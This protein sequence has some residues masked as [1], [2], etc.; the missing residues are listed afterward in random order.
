MTLI[1]RFLAA[2]ACLALLGGVPTLAK[3]AFS[4]AAVQEKV[5]RDY[6]GV[7]QLSTGA[8][9]ERLAGR[10]DVLLL[11]V[12]E[13]QEFAVS[14]IAGAQRVDP[15]IW[16]S[17]FLKRFGNTAQG[18]TVVFYCSVGVRSSKLAEKVQKQ[19]MAQGAQGVFNLD[20][21]IFAWHNEARAL[22]NAKG[23]TPFVHP[24]DSYWGKLLKRQ[25]LA[26][27]SLGKP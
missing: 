25:E 17:T 26:R 13:A 1:V 24:Y 4:L 19:L 12:R 5:K 18:K 16:R 14:H 21:G 20:G 7:A 6:D 27:T 8:L 11:D 2:V 10:K 22:V 23:E 15:G 3:D 9:A